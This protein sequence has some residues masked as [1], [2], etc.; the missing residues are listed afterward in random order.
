M[1]ESPFS[2]LL[3]PLHSTL[4]HSIPLR[5]ILPHS[6]PLHFTLHSPLYYTLLHSTPLHSTQCFIPFHSTT[7]HHTTPHHSIPFQ[8]T[9]L[10]STSTQLS[11]SLASFSFG[12]NHRV[13][14]TTRY[15]DFSCSALPSLSVSLSQF[16]FS[17]F[18]V[19]LYPIPLSSSPLLLLLI[20]PLVPSF[21]V[22]FYLLSFTFLLSFCPFAS[23]FILVYFFFNSLTRLYICL[24]KFLLFLRW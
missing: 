11:S 23:A 8:S 12:C 7:P 20:L 3:F 16:Y 15:L 5:S 10:H 14:A 18:F 2:A 22:N 24:Y 21:F 6:T 4:L 1:N 19:L 13:Q 9:P 17:P